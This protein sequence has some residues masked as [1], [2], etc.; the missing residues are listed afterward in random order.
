MSWPLPKTGLL[1]PVTYTLPSAPTYNAHVGERSENAWTRPQIQSEP[2][3]VSALLDPTEPSLRLC[4]LTNIASSHCKR[5][6]NSLEMGMWTKLLE[7]EC[8]S[9]LIISYFYFH[10]CKR[11]WLAAHQCTPLPSTCDVLLSRTWT[12][13]SPRI[14]QFFIGHF[15]S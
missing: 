8:L 5:G 13:E 7:S 1:Q 10:C 12:L 15:K 4:S 11:V 9:S 14:Q 6:R 2:T 3:Q